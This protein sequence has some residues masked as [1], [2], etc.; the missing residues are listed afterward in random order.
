MRHIAIKFN[1]I[2]NTNPRNIFNKIAFSFPNLMTL[3]VSNKF[4]FMI[5][6][7]RGFFP[8]LYPTSFI[9]MEGKKINISIN[10]VFVILFE[11]AYTILCISQ[12]S[13]VFYNFQLKI[14]QILIYY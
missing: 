5:H 1:T 12:K 3:D 6:E 13:S 11:Q 2:N 4:V 8:I 7:S 10:F 14:Y 9:K